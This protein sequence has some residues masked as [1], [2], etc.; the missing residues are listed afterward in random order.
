MILDGN[1]DGNQK[2]IFIPKSSQK[3][4]NPELKDFDLLTWAALALI[5]IFLISWCHFVG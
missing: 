4:Q 2:C 1:I 5:N 3:W